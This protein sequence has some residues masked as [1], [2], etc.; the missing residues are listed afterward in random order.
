MDGMVILRG[1]QPQRPAA[2]ALVEILVEVGVSAATAARRGVAEYVRAVQMARVRREMQGLS[3]HYLRDI[4][5]TRND[6]E[7]TFR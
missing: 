3:D 7:R 4:G 1:S 5:L 2:Y 6:I